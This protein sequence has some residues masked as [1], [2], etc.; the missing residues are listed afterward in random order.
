MNAKVK[1]NLTPGAT[2]HGSGETSAIVT[3]TMSDMGGKIITV[4][5]YRK[6]DWF[7]G[8]GYVWHRSMFEWVRK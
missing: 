5:Q 4:T 3:R 8:E 6:P 7:K 1:T 2:V